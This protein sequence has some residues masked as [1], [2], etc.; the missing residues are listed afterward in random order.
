MNSSVTANATTFGSWVYSRAICR[1]NT[2]K[3]RAEETSK[4]TPIPRAVHPARPACRR[5]PEPV[6]RPTDTAAADAIP[7]GTMYATAAAFMAMACRETHRVQRA[8]ESRRSVEHAD[9]ETDGEGGRQSQ[10]EKFA[11]ALEQI[12]HLTE[13]LGIAAFQGNEEHRGQINS[14]EDSGEGGAAYAE[15]WQ[16]PMSEDQQPVSEHIDQVGGDQRESDRPNMMKRLNV[17]AQN[18]VKEQER[19]TP[20]QHVGKGD[21]LDAN[22]PGDTDEGQNW[23]PAEDAGGKNRSRAYA[24]SESGCKGAPRPK[25]ILRAE[26]VGNERVEPGQET[27]SE[28]SEGVEKRVADA[29]GADRDG[30][31]GQPSDHDGVDHAHRHPAQ[32]GQR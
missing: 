19:Q 20:D 30:A 5:S 16:S 6:A 24:E 29:G 9:F 1:G 17:A 31:V 15:G 7:S 23:R 22:W 26:C 25:P 10:M 12:A 13:R 11:D 4:T 21:R 27:D 3:E 8:D 2:R 14:G 28:N 18:G 32:F